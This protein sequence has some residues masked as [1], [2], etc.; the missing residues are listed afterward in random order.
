M[1]GTLKPRRYEI[2]TPE[3]LEI[4]S[5][6]NQRQ[7]SKVRLPDFGWI[8][9]SSDRR[10]AELMLYF[11]KQRLNFGPVARVRADHWTRWREEFL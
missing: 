11:E 8:S 7:M 10:D 2:G 9:L 3:D 4:W 5:R 6:F 1:R